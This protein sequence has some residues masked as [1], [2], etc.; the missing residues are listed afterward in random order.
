MRCPLNKYLDRIRKPRCFLLY[1]LAPNNLPAAE[2]NH[3]LNAT[4]GDPSL[5]LAIS[6]DHFIGQ[7]GGFVIFFVETQTEREALLRQNYLQGW[8]VELQP[9]I[10]SRNPAAMDE[11]IAYTLRAHA[12]MDWDTVRHIE[13]PSYGNPNWEAQTALKD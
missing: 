11:Q 9:L 7:A 6:H 2:A 3:I 1:A 12:E 13:R 5:P 8:H 10:Y 4:L